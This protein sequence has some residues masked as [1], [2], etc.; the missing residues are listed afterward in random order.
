MP[1]FNR[2]LVIANRQI[3]DVLCTTPL[4]R[5]VAKAWPHATIHVLGYEGTMGMLTG[6]QNVNLVIESP[7]HPKLRCYVP[8]FKRIFRKYDLAIVTQ[9]SDRAHLYGFVAASTRIGIVPPNGLHAWWKKWM[10]RY[11]LQMSGADRH[12]VVDRYYL[13]KNFLE[14]YQTSSNKSLI[15]VT[16]SPAL[17]ELVPPSPQALPVNFEV[18]TENPYVVVHATPMWK[19]K[20]WPI[21]HWGH[22]IDS[23]I[24]LGYRVVLT[25]STR[26]EDKTINI[27]IINC[28]ATNHRSHLLDGSGKLSLGQV[29]ALLSRAAAYIGVDTSITHQAAAVGVKTIAIFGPTSPVYFGPWPKETQL[30]FGS[31]SAWQPIA[32]DP[33][34]PQRVKNVTIVQGTSDCVPCMRMGCDNN[35][36]SDSKCL[37][38]LDYRR[39]LEAVQEI[40]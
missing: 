40:L 7:E 37:E 35:N 38:D 5:H 19:Y 34:S 24:S 28:V 20:Q 1:E 8:L 9:A 2:I 33:K 25:G 23:I 13:I 22:L 6:N 16:K 4:I 26:D 14:K 39:V 15:S 36:H 31:N 21:T 12:V 18:F 3:G 32:M 27:S 10:C 17:I 30:G 29:S 11:W